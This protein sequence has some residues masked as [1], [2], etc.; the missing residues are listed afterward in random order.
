MA[1][2]DR[3]R[4][5]A[6][7]RGHF[8]IIVPFLDPLLVMIH[9]FSMVANQFVV[10]FCIIAEIMKSRIVM[11]GYEGGRE[12]EF[13]EP[14]MTEIMIFAPR[15][16]YTVFG[17]TQDNKNLNK[18]WREDEKKADLFERAGKDE[19]K[20]YRFGSKTGTHGFCGICGSSMFVYIQWE[21]EK[22]VKMEINVSRAL[23]ST[24]IG[25]PLV[26]GRGVISWPGRALLVLFCTILNA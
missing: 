8:D 17:R 11:R 1:R 18:T 12:L 15:N 9:P 24:F 4:A 3:P 16:S 21:G 26:R 2:R 7:I 23:L 25:R 22:K 6:I 5:M 19:L 10:A 14:F 20:E 13:L